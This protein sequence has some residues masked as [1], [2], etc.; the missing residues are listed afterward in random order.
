MEESEASKRMARRYCRMEW[1]KHTAVEMA[2]RAKEVFL[3]KEIMS[4]AS[5]V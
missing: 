5:T 4:L 3:E 2:W 1:R